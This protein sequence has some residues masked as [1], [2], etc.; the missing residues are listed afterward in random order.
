MKSSIDYII[1][2][3]EIFIKRF[4]KVRVRYEYDE[5][6]IIHIIEVVP[7]EI[8]HLDEEYILWESEMF[9]KFV[10]RYPTENVCFISDDALVGIENAVLTL[11]GINYAPFSTIQESVTFDVGIKMMKQSIFN[12]TFSVDTEK[13]IHIEAVQ[14]PR[15]YSSRTYSL[16][17]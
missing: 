16:A 6:A 5:K 3:L 8:Y 12:G 4:S 13:N 2:E 11:Y 1:S 10:T 15:E 17:A 9:D 14:V 7:N